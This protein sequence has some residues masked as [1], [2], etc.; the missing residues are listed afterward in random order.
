MAAVAI[1]GVLFP[2]VYFNAIQSKGSFS[3]ELA[4]VTFFF[5]IPVDQVAKSS[6]VLKRMGCDIGLVDVMFLDLLLSP[7]FLVPYEISGLLSRC[8]PG[9]AISVAACGTDAFKLLL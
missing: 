8:E 4:R 7:L 6:K 9:S 2:P 1:I 5:F 3:L